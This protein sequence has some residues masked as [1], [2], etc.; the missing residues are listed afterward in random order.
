MRLMMPAAVVLFLVACSGGSDETSG[1]ADALDE[2][3]LAMLMAEFP[4]LGPDPLP[5]PEP[6][7]TADPADIPD[8][9]RHSGVLQT[10]SGEATFYA[11]SFE[12]R[13]TASGIPFRQ[14]QMVAAHRAFPFGTILRVTNTRNDRS[15]QVRVVDRGPHGSSAA[16]RRTVIDLSQRAAAELGYLEAGR[17]RVRVEVLEWGTGIPS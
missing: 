3:R 5:E 6:A 7:G 2:S 10:V 14:N 1:G 16:A 13:R 15:V 9:V 17:A 11:K 4:R 8:R 12:G